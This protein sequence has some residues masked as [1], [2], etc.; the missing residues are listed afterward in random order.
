MKKLLM[1]IVAAVAVVMKKRLLTTT[2]ALVALIASAHAGDLACQGEWTDM[3]RIGLTIGD[4]DLNYISDKDRTKI[5]QVC[6][7]PWTPDRKGEAPL[8]ALRVEFDGVK[9]RKVL[10]VSKYPASTANVQIPAKMQGQWCAYPTGGDG[11]DADDHGWQ[12]YRRVPLSKAKLAARTEGN[13][14][15]FILNAKTEQA[16]EGLCRF[17]E[18]N[19]A[20]SGY[21]VTA[22]CGG[23][24]N[25]ELWI[26][27]L[28]YEL[29]GKDLVVTRLWNSE[30][31]DN[32]DGIARQ[33][34]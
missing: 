24:G 19:R 21:E 11:V 29:E 7:K 22:K 33:R 1:A 32:K 13:G 31:G 27:K 3:R 10:E 20:K 15:C 6:G 18:V 26:N 12:R 4:C 30:E 23:V 17:T 5:E 2:T 16:Y 25:E 9:V 28:R 8:C 34:K 14:S